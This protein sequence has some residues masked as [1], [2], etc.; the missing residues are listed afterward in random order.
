MK[1]L[2]FIALA[3]LPATTFAQN[4]K[5]E[6]KGVVT[7]FFND[8]F[9]DKPDVGAKVVIQKINPQLVHS[10][11][12]IKYD[13]ALVNLK[14]H[15]A[16]LE[17][18]IN[19]QNKDIAALDTTQKKTVPIKKTNQAIKNKPAPV[20][21]KKSYQEILDKEQH[22]HEQILNDNKDFFDKSGKSFL[23]YTEYYDKVQ[24]EEERHYH[25]QMNIVDTFGKASGENENKIKWR[26]LEIEK[27]LNLAKKK[28]AEERYKT[29]TNEL[30]YQEE[31]DSYKFRTN[32]YSEMT[33][34][35]NI[36]HTL[37]MA[38][39]E[40][41]YLRIAP[42]KKFKNEQI[43]KLKNLNAYPEEKFN[44]L[45]KRVYQMVSDI[46][47]GQDTKTTTVDGNG[48]YSIKL[49]AGIYYL[50]IKSKGRK[51]HSITESD[52]QI[53]GIDI[54]EIKSNDVVEKSE[55]FKGGY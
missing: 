35:I 55:N 47:Y 37:K 30:K 51:A 14:R 42:T 13:S 33:E 43:E 3:I 24:N 53:S 50:I 39:M 16:E 9:G 4:E 7:Y 22:Q 17:E 18:T 31:T 48:N 12:E 26:H 36:I 40:N 6:L 8:N 44:E 10:P 29:V 52:G 25:E 5:G 11:Q 38:E 19:K 45:D 20:A 28:N 21:K 1:T 23:A 27:Q 15:I 49:D 54:V 2:L 32:K 34:T 46:E 41:E